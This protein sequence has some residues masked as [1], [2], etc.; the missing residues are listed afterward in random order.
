[1]ASHAAAIEAARAADGAAEAASK[2]RD[3]EVAAGRAQQEE[4]ALACCALSPEGGVA[5]AEQQEQAIQALQLAMR[6]LCE[7]ESRHANTVIGAEQA[8]TAAWAHAASLAQ[9]LEERT[10][11]AETRATAAEGELTAIKA[12]LQVGGTRLTNLQAELTALQNTV[13][14]SAAAE[15]AADA[16]TAAAEAKVGTAEAKASSAVSK[17]AATETKLIAAETKLTT[18]EA[19]ANTADE[20]QAQ[21]EQQLQQLQQLQQQLQPAASGAA[22]TPMERRLMSMA[23]EYA[24]AQ[25]DNNM[26]DE[27][28]AS[29]ISQFE[30]SI[31][32]VKQTTQKRQ[33]VY[34]QQQA[35][36]SN[37][38][39]DLKQQ[40]AGTFVHA[41]TPCCTPA[42][43]CSNAA[44][45]SDRRGRG[46]A[47]AASTSCKLR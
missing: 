7:L 29:A 38:M 1:M 26:E 41:F 18:A 6:K 23:H 16:K 12:E 36:L 39:A 22:S 19:Q 4:R 14:A 46:A 47:A 15:K 27:K 17:L 28:D 35:K 30:L 31:R 43:S 44:F 45:G 24:Q 37:D 20:Q 10:S 2:A 34:K 32:V 33:I 21:Q 3:R 25:M 9:G 40:I 8:A 5:S 11:A 13:T 42:A